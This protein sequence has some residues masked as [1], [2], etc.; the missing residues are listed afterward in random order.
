MGPVYPYCLPREIPPRRDFCLKED[1]KGDSDGLYLTGSAMK[2]SSSSGALSRR[3]AVPVAALMIQWVEIIEP[4]TQER[5]Y[6]NLITGDCL[7]D[8]PPGVPVF[9]T[10]VVPFQEKKKPIDEVPET[11]VGLVRRIFVRI[12][13]EASGLKKCVEWKRQHCDR[14]V[15]NYSPVGLS[16]PS[17]MKEGSTERNLTVQC[18]GMAWMA[19]ATRGVIAE[20]FM[21]NSARPEGGRCGSVEE[22]PKEDP[23]PSAC[24]DNSLSTEDA[25]YLESADLRQLLERGRVVDR[26]GMPPKSFPVVVMF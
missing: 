14:M 22:K 7:R 19:N 17:V 18:G 25:W 26:N 24:P 13:V 3:N 5:V 9:Q 6:A 23:G 2:T 12:F 21:S 16:E 20:H 1:L 15:V 11:E 4:R 10:Q 8:P